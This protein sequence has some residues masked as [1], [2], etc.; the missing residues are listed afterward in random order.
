MNTACSLTSHSRRCVTEDPA[1]I[2]SSAWTDIRSFLIVLWL[3]LPAVLGLAGSLLI[4]HGLIPSLVASGDLRDPR[5]QK[6][7]P[8]FYGVAAFSFVLVIAVLVVGISWIE[9]VTGVYERWWV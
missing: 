1:F 8:V 3:L 7:R 2:T 9:L 6:L 4:A 5:I